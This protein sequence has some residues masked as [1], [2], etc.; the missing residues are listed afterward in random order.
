MPTS[1]QPRGS[2]N[3][4]CRVRTERKIGKIDGGGRC[5]HVDGTFHALCTWTERRLP[6]ASH[7]FPNI[8]PQIDVM[9]AAARHRNPV[10]RISHYD[11]EQITIPIPFT[12]PYETKK[13]KTQQQQ[14]FQHKSNDGCSIWH[15]SAVHCRAAIQLDLVFKL[16]TRRNENRE[17]RATSIQLVII[18][19]RIINW[20]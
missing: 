7:V 2:R 1:T 5:G 12:T 10:E 8:W 6:L 3:F 19:K 17:K 20:K 13:K 9:H 15:E 16:A 4:S 18:I 14:H 11:D